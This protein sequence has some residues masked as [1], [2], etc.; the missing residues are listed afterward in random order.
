MGIVYNVLFTDFTLLLGLE[1]ILRRFRSV[2][3]LSKMERLDITLTKFTKLQCTPVDVRFR[4]YTQNFLSLNGMSWYKTN[5]YTE[6][7]LILSSF[8]LLPRARGT[9]LAVISGSWSF[10][11]LACQ[12][13]FHLKKISLKKDERRAI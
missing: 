7:P 4:V 1:Y 2:S 12:H 13:Y 5:Y 10:S 8:M 3:E 11:I 6:D 9:L